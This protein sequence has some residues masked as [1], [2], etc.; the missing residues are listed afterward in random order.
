MSKL[1]SRQTVAQPLRW[2]EAENCID[3]EKIA[4]SKKGAV[5]AKKKF[6]KKVKKLVENWI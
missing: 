5:S 3:G 1:Q 4:S 2:A 6:I